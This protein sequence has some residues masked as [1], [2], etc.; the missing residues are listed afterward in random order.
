MAFKTPQLAEKFIKSVRMRVS[1]GVCESE[2]CHQ[3]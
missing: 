2:R 1:V 3:V